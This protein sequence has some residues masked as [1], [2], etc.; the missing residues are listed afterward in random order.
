[1]TDQ[2]PPTTT[3][4]PPID[5]LAADYSLGEFKPLSQM[6]PLC[7]HI[8]GSGS[9]LGGRPEHRP[10]DQTRALVTLMAGMGAND[11]DISLV[12]GIS[13]PTLTKYYAEQLAAAA[14]KMDFHVYSAMYKAIAKGKT[15]MIKLYLERRKGWKA[16]DV[17]PSVNVNVSVTIDD[18]VKEI[19]S[20]PHTLPKWTKD[21]FKTIEHERTP[22]AV[23]NKTV[24]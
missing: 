2:Q 12:I 22:D 21:D 14:A 9:G 19:S 3:T 13:R 8:P 17:D 20:K 18:I 11:T 15:D 5:D 6:V 1:M 23:E 16:D 4:I 24:D 10:T 7:P